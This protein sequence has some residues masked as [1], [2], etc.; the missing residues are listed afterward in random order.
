MGSVATKWW[1]S[2]AVTATPPSRLFYTSEGTEIR[3]FSPGRLVMLVDGRATQQGTY[4]IYAEWTAELSGAGLESSSQVKTE[5]TARTPWCTRPGH[6]GFWTGVGD[7]A[8]SRIEDL[9]G[10]EAR[11]G[12]F[13]KL[14]YPIT[15]VQESGNVKTAHWVKTQDD[16]SLLPC[17]EAPTDVDTGNMKF[18]NLVLPKGT[19]VADI[20]PASVKGEAMA[21]SLSGYPTMTADSLRLLSEFARVLGC[22]IE[23]SSP[24]DELLKSFSTTSLSQREQSDSTERS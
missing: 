14:P 16:N 8:S 7:N 19:M 6:Q 3:E 10:S 4:T 9:L 24:L 2:T 23:T 12:R 22:F 18:E 13:F 15:L 1:Q 5:W 11:I 21:P 17:Y 20:T